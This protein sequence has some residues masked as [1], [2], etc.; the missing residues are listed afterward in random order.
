MTK[1]IML[2]HGAWLNS[3][4][5]EEG[6]ARYEGKGFTVVSDEIKGLSDRTENS[7]MEI[8]KLIK[9]VQNETVEAV[10]V[11]NSGL[12]KINAGK[13]LLA[14]TKAILGEIGD[15]AN[16]EIERIGMIKRNAH[17]QLKSSENIFKAVETITFNVREI[18]NHVIGSKRDSS[19]ILGESGKMMNITRSVKNAIGEQNKRNSEVVEAFKEVTAKVAKL[20]DGMEKQTTEG[21]EII[22]IVNAVKELAEANLSETN[23]AV[24]SSRELENAV[25]ILKTEVMKFKV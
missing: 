12:E 7:T 23:D 25:K 10:A 1:T 8:H 16:T 19:S 2:I 3:K 13:E 4:G 11:M 5:W 20:I 22:S 14:K 15:S 9:V 24:R 21:R 17:E 6:K 18:L